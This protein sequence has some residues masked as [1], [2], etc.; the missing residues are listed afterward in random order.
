MASVEMFF[1]AS[2]GVKGLRG[3]CVGMADYTTE[4]RPGQPWRTMRSSICSCQA[5]RGVVWS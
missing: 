1:M 3:L 5:S 2:P 4:E